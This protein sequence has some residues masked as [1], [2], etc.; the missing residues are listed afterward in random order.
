MIFKFV[1]NYNL[2]TERFIFRG[3]TFRPEENSERIVN[4]SNSAVSALRRKFY[5]F[6]DNYAVGTSRRRRK[7]AM[8]ILY[9]SAGESRRG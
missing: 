3:G 7:D 9:G 2:F 5:D 1:T 8:S 4:S 6:G